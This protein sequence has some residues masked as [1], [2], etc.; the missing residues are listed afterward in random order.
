[1]FSLFKTQVKD[2]DYFINKFEKIPESKWSG[3]DW[4]VDGARCVN[5]HCG[6]GRDNYA[7]GTPESIALNKLFDKIAV[8]T[9][10]RNN[11]SSFYWWKTVSVNDGNTK[12]YQQPTPKQRILAALYDIKNTQQSKEEK[13]KV[14]HVYHQAPA[15]ITL[16]DS[17]PEIVES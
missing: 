10:G 6:V 5:G 1:M 2:V 7:K 4:E 8:T 14:I 12:E 11:Y 15:F 17:L 16:H 13:P 9:I 3:M